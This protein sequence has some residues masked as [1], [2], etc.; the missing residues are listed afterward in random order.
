VY[1]F[2]TA[3][4]PAH[5]H[6]PQDAEGAI[7]ALSARFVGFHPPVPELIRRTEKQ[8]LVRTDIH[9]RDPLSSWSA[10]RVTLL[11][12]AA[13]PM[14][15][16]LGQGGCQAI[17]DAVVLARALGEHATPEAAFRAYE[18]A[19]IVR[20]NALVRRSR[21]LGEVAQWQGVVPRLLRDG[22]LRLTP[23]SVTLKQMR[24]VL[25]FQA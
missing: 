12:D 10:G 2:A 14:T 11:G 6:D 18:A 24:E 8:K 4:E 17:E 21:T 7:A 13:H 16:N 19:R 1:W 15:P 5:G 20:A 3:N 22:A 23:R 9:D 25:T